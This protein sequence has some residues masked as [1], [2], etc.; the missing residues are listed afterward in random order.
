MGIDMERYKQFEDYINSAKM[1]EAGKMKDAALEAYAAG[2]Y[3]KASAAAAI[4]NMYIAEQAL[5]QST[6]GILSIKRDRRLDKALQNKRLAQIDVFV[7]KI[8]DKLAVTWPECACG[9]QNYDP[10]KFEHCYMC[11]KDKMAEAS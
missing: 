5:F 1:M 6:D 4:A 7:Q 3:A 11:H 2:D 10:S 8:D 9:R